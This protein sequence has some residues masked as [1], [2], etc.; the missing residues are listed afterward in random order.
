MIKPSKATKSNGIKTLG[1]GIPFSS[2]MK[3]KSSYFCFK[4]EK[5]P[6]FSSVSEESSTAFAILKILSN[7]SFKW[8]HECMKEQEL[9]HT[10]SILAKSKSFK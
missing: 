9:Q 6:G 7:K 5:K 1:A 4:L 10:G 2:N 3:M 8:I